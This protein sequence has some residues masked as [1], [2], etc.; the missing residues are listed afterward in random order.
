MAQKGDEAMTVSKFQR[1]WQRQSTFTCGICGKLT[2]DTGDNGS[3]GLCPRCFEESEQENALD[4]G[5]ITWEE[6]DRAIDEI[7]KKYSKKKK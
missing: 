2:R 7:D 3:V 6:Y 4:D 5:R 1:N